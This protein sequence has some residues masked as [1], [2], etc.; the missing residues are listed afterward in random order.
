[1][2]EM[3]ILFSLLFAAMLFVSCGGDIFEDVTLD[4]EGTAKI[5][6]GNVVVDQNDGTTFTKESVEAA[7]ALNDD[8]TMTIFMKKVKFASLMPAINM[9]IPGVTI[10]G[11]DPNMTLSGDSIVPIAMGGEFKKFTITGL[12]GYVNQDT[13]NMSFTCGDYPVTYSGILQKK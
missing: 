10:V 12:E 13:F 6:V 7:Y 2:R 8:G 5:F 9:E 11:E 4:E 3:R 1:M